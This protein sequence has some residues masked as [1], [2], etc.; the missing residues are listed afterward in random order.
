[1]T[2]LVKPLLHI[3]VLLRLSHQDVTYPQATNRH[4]EGACNITMLT[5]ALL[6]TVLLRNRYHPDAPSIL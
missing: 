4:D 6:A 5:G 2:V 3:R 1:M